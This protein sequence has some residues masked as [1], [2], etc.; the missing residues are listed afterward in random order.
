MQPSSPLTRAEKDERRRSKTFAGCAAGPPPRPMPRPPPSQQPSPSASSPAAVLSGGRSLPAAAGSTAPQRPPSFG[1]GQEPPPKVPLK[2]TSSSFFSKAK[3]DKKEAKPSKPGKLSKSFS[4]PSSS[5]ITAA[6]RGADGTIQ[7]LAVLERQKIIIQAIFQGETTNRDFRNVALE[8]YTSEVSYVLSLHRVMLYAIPEAQ[9]IYAKHPETVDGVFGNIGEV[10]DLHVAF[11]NDLIERYKTWSEQSCLGDVLRSHFPNFRAVYTSYCAHYERASQ[12]LVRDTKKKEINTLCDKVQTSCE[13]PLPALLIMPVQRLPR[14]RMLLEDL[15]RK[16]EKAYGTQHPDYENLQGALKV[17]GSI[18]DD[19]NTSLRNAASQKTVENV[20]KTVKGSER[21]LSA[22]NRKIIADADNIKIIVQVAE[23][24]IRGVKS[25]Q[26]TIT[27]YDRAI[28]LTDS[29][30]FCSSATNPKSDPRHTIEEEVALH[31]L[32][33]DDEV[34]DGYDRFTALRFL[35]PEQDYVVTCGSRLE[36]ESWRSTVTD[37]IQT[38]VDSHSLQGPPLESG[39]SVR[40]FEYNFSSESPVLPGCIY[41]GDWVAAKP[42]GCGIIHFESASSKLIY[43]GQ[44]QKGR[45]TG[46]GKMS[47]PNGF[48]YEGQWQMDVPHGHG[49][50][51]FHFGGAFSYTG[52]FHLGKRHSDSECDCRWTLDGLQVSYLGPFKMDRICGSGTFTIAGL[53][54]YEGEMLNDVFQGEGRL[55]YHSGEVLQG[56]FENGLLSGQGTVTSPT[57]MTYTGAF[58]NG[59]YHGEGTLVDP[60]IGCYTGSFVD[61]IFHGVGFL[62]QNDGTSYRGAW[63]Y[64]YAHGGGKYLRLSPE[65][66]SYEGHFYHG[67]WQGQGVLVTDAFKYS[68][69]FEASRPHGSGELAMLFGTYTGGFKFGL[70]HGEGNLTMQLPGATQLVTYNGSWVNNSMH[71]KGKLVSPSGIYDGEWVNGL[72]HGQ[73]MLVQADFTYSGAWVNGSRAGQ[74]TVTTNEGLILGGEWLSG[75]LHGPVTCTSVASPNKPDQLFFKDGISQLTV[76][77][78]LIPIFDPQFTTLSIPFAPPSMLTHQMPTCLQFL[79]TFSPLSN[80]H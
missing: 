75:R 58:L 57:G 50:I 14:Y 45:R 55:E 46:V 5:T 32:W 12:L 24:S 11:L 25:G 1:D 19:I 77:A 52:G 48:V 23:A 22:P 65:K 67:L 54:K 71:G 31:T 39:E 53:L 38:W 43:E 73:G 13:Q 79:S 20:M 2:K 26:A 70:R 27:Y 36:R 4:L 64:G 37:V 7:A 74:A 8:I 61:G 72:P 3:P 30:V 35:T 78:V 63:E 56:R 29:I 15:L 16:L 42:E 69:T 40:K 6:R 34:P 68:G 18:A 9:K 60:T 47:W 80:Q 10:R 62:E 76:G 49:T 28:L 21:F 41:R 44:V 59:L 17:I 66:I 33:V 51:S